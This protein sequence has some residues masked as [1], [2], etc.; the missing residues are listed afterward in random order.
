M[1]SSDS[2]LQLLQIAEISNPSYLAL[3]PTLQY[4]YSVNEITD[5]G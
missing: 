2:G 5:G 1:N 3:D 4:L